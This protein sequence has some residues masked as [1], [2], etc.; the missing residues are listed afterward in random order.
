MNQNSTILIVDDQLSAREVLKGMLTMQGYD[1]LFASNG[2]EA[3]SQAAQ[4][5]PDLILLDVMMPDMDGFEV[6]RQI[7]AN[8][9]LAEVPIILVTA[10]DD[11]KSRVTGIEAGADDF[12]TKP[13]SFPE[14]S[15]RVRNTTRLNR[16][17]QL[18]SIRKKFDWVM[19][20]AND[21]YVLLDNQDHLLYANTKARLYLGL[22]EDETKLP[23]PTFL[24]LVQQQY[25]CK[26]E[27]VWQ[28][29]PPASQTE[30]SPRYLVRPESATVNTLWLRINTLEVSDG[31]W[32]VHLQDV[33]AQMALQR[34][35]WGFQ[36]MVSHKLR[37]PLSGI[38]TG[39]DL[40]DNTGF[41][42][43]LDSDTVE[44]YQL[45]SRSAT[46][47]NKEIDTIL[48]YIKTP[49][50]VHGGGGVPL[51]QLQQIMTQVSVSLELEN[52]TIATP[53]ASDS[54]QILLGQQ[55]LELI[56]QEILGNSKKFH[57]QQKP[58]LEIWASPINDNQQ[59]QIQISDDGLTLPSEQL[60]HVWTPYYQVEKYF[61]GEVS[62]MGLGLTKVAMLVWSVDGA[63]RMN[64]RT[65]GPGVT[66]EF[67]LPLNHNS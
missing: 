43:H 30:S 13:V 16:Y 12:L 64:N 46:R 15:A 41:L 27:D 34:E 7:R 6:C 36:K 2:K 67:T 62:G 38:I 26:P 10:L 32:V 65:P 29:W 48:R 40:L 60:T 52:I 33:T 11:L 1:L 24:T 3:L 14:L 31:D 63:C 22:A 18:L 50:T 39:M 20:Q 9:L 35:V 58:G 45:I 59:L 44:L 37:T 49:I 17:R 28:E 8:P 4:F 55:S 42:N 51:N 21:G 66:V 5:T 56:L 61:T 19:D 53:P 47:L 25:R 54:T 57:P 23:L